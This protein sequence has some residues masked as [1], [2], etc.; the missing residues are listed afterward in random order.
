M[1]AE[2][3]RPM[4]L[5][6]YLAFERRSEVKHEYLDGTL[7][8]MAGASPNHNRIQKSLL[9]YLDPFAERRGCELFGSDLRVRIEALNIFTYP[10]LVIARG[11]SQFDREALLNAVVII[12]ILSPSTEGNDRMKKF[13][14]YRRSPTLREYV[15]IAQDMPFIEHYARQDNGQ[16]LL[17]VAEQLDETIF[18]PAIDCDL[19]LIEVYKRV[20]F[21][22]EDAPTGMKL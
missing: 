7:V 22:A 8:A 13:A 5:E 17:S 2:P 21:P 18:L 12:E 19:P 4:T 3:Q 16:W 9:I 15:L 14:R 10:D 11:A 20:A 6:E 1:V